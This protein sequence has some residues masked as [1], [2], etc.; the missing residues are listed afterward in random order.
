VDIY[1]LGAILYELLTGQPPFRGPTPLDTVMQVIGQEPPRPRSLDKTIDRDLETIVLKCLAKEPSQRYASAEVLADELDRWQG[2]EPILARR[3]R[4]PVRMWRWGRRN[5]AL[6]FTSTAALVG[7]VAAAS[8]LTALVLS[9]TWTIQDMTLQAVEAD[10]KRG[11]RHSAMRDLLRAREWQHGL[12]LRQEAIES[13][14]MAGIEPLR[15]FEFA[16]QESVRSNVEPSPFTLRVS[17]DGKTVRITTP[18]LIQER[19]VPS[20]ELLSE[21]PA[22]PNKEMQAPA[23]RLPD[24][25]RVL[26]LSEDAKWA[27]AA[28]AKADAV[29][30][31]IVLWDVTA[32]KQVQE[33]T[34]I[35]LP[36]PNYACVSPDGRRMAYIDT[37]TGGTIK[38]YDWTKGRY[39]SILPHGGTNILENQAGFSP[40]GSLLAFKGLPGLALFDVERGQPA[41]ALYTSEITNSAWSRDGRWLITMGNGIS[42]LEQNRG[43]SIHAYVHFSEVIYPTP[44]YHSENTDFANR[45]RFYRDGSLLAFNNTLGEVVPGEQRTT[46]KPQ[47]A[48]MPKGARLVVTDS[49]TWSLEPNNWRDDDNVLTMR[50]L[51]PR[52]RSIAFKHPGFTD[53]QLRKDG[54]EPVPRLCQ[55]AVNPDGTRLLCLFY[56]D[57]PGQAE[58]T[59]QWSLELWDRP[60]AERL[61][62]WNAGGYDEGFFSL[63]FTPDGKQVLTVGLNG[64]TIW[65]AATGQI[66][67]T[68]LDKKKPYL[69]MEEAPGKSMQI[70]WHQNVGQEIAFRAD[71]AQFAWLHET[72]GHEDEDMVTLHDTATGKKLRGWK[73]PPLFDGGGVA[74]HPDGRWLAVGGA[75]GSKNTPGG[76]VIL[77]DTASGNKLAEWETKHAWTMFLAFS[78][79]GQTLVTGDGS[80][81]EIWNLTWIRKEL[82][83]LKLDW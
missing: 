66:E 4:F 12:D 38:I 76:S 28:P 37:E 71:G 80:T 44:M 19:A 68:L 35:T 58:T 31:R 11:D 2:G 5:K 75:G 3:V 82:A 26:G 57:Y 14:T 64:L 54:K 10:R 43:V 81:L 22:S 21:E 51:T 72:I 45:I 29:D 16:G 67:Q 73:R 17:S 46:W 34:N 8:F 74:L 20:A 9:T 39:L 47:P 32:G 70:K 65:D 23:V 48:A 7:L 6:A 33:L 40:N 15:Q 30:K 50:Q 79:D 18:K 36:Y 13:I 52:E 62:V 60:R 53:P 1:S 49:E 41:G 24:G 59:P 78:P 25:L 55:T 27:V 69:K 77:Y 61:A 63:E 83:A 42:G 56:L